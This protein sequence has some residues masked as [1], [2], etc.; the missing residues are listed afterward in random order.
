M[1]DDDSLTD[2]RQRDARLRTDAAA[3]LVTGLVLAGGRGTRMGGRDKGLIDWQGKPLVAAVIAGLAPQVDRL[4][5]NANRHLERYAGFGLPVWPDAGS[6]FPGPLA[7]MLAGL[8]HCQTDWLAV[9]PC[10]APLLPHDL[11]ERLQ[12]A[13]RASSGPA[14]I[15]V[16]PQGRQPVFCLLRR[17]TQPVLQAYVERGGRKVGEALAILGAVAAPFDDDA[18]FLNVNEPR[19]LAALPARPGVPPR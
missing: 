8:H 9:V 12:H 5:L 2:S 13:T 6:D 7:G 1:R 10:D 16:S 14:A 19:D 18:P 3:G 11:V 17:D 15:A 4:A